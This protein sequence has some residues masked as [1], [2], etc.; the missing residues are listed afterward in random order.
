MAYE[1]G[2][3][4][5]GVGQTYGSNMG[6]NIAAHTVSTSGE[7]RLVF[8]FDGASDMSHVRYTFPEGHAVISRAYVEVDHGFT[9]G[10]V[11]VAFGA[12]PIGPTPAPLTSAGIIEYGLATY[13]VPVVPGQDI[14]LLL[15]SVSYLQTGALA[16]VIVEYTRA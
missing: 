11:D 16:K 3:N 8:E 2:S 13:P 1:S 4:G 7:G 10:T 12:F 5:L 6:G 15:T 9:S 14:S